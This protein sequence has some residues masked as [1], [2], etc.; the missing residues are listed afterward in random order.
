MDYRIS[1]NCDEVDWKRLSAILAEVGMTS[2]EPEVHER[3]FRASPVV[4]FAFAG[5]A[6]VGFGRALSDGVK[7]AGIFDVAVDPA[8]QGR[9][10]GSAIMQ[11]LMERFAG[12][13]VILFANPGREEFYARFGFKMLKTAMA[14]FPDEERFRRKGVID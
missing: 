10:I 12:L 3:L 11:D 5:D 6:L 1:H 8:H 2:L 13:N 7:D 9:G 14:R 4:A